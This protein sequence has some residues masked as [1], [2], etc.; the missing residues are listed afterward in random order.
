MKA[1]G[2]LCPLHFMVTHQ[3]VLFFV[4]HI[5]YCARALLFVF[6]KAARNEGVSVEFE[7]T[8]NRV[9]EKLGVSVVFSERNLN[10]TS[11]I[12]GSIKIHEIKAD[13]FE[14]DP[15]LCR[16]AIGYL[17]DFTHRLY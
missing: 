10:L 7:F 11:M 15:E 14:D 12:M 8:C 17:T 16:K 4:R 2:K 3:L 9:P 5:R 1:R 6:F 13:T